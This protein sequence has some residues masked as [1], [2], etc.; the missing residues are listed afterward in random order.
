[1]LKTLSNFNTQYKITTILILL[2]IL[3]CS[4]CK[5]ETENTQTSIP[6]KY[7]KN[8]FYLSN[9][10]HQTIT[11]SFYYEYDS[12]NQIT[13]KEFHN[14]Q[15][16]YRYQH[17][18]E[19]VSDTVKEYLYSIDSLDSYS[20]SY[21]ISS[22]QTRK[23]KYGKTRLKPGTHPD[24]I[25]F[26][27]YEIRENNHCNYLVRIENYDWNENLTSYSTYSYSGNNGK[28][29][30]NW[31]NANNQLL[32]E[33]EATTNNK[34]SAYNTNPNYQ[35]FLKAIST[36][37]LTD[38]SSSIGNIDTYMYEYELDDDNYPTQMINTHME[39]GDINMRMYEYY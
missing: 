26:L 18:Y 19:Y 12:Q 17:R 9:T 1:M 24:S 11:Q 10:S 23:D 32:R 31:F 33:Q 16:N 14:H 20:V 13:L 4:S 25:T 15:T 34:P 35:C 21:P 7:L 6:V 38:Y 37:K 39:T 28:F 3:F 22:T 8:A 36:Q 27:S 2:G 30:I 5:K 29:I